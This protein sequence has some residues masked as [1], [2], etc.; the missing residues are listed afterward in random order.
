M[1]TRTRVDDTDGRQLD[2]LVRALRPR[3]PDVA[4]RNRIADL[5]W[6]AD[7]GDRK[8][9]GVLAGAEEAVYHSAATRCVAA[10]SL[11]DVGPNL[12]AARPLGQAVDDPERAFDHVV[13][14]WA[15]TNPELDY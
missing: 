6:D 10:V 5:L 15:W 9:I 14:A 11:T 8:L 2:S 3:T 4:V 1:S 12:G 7:H 13:D